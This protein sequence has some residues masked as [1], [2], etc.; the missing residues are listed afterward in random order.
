MS[1]PFVRWLSA[2]LF[3]VRCCLCG[4]VV[5]WSEHLCSRCRQEAPYI[6]PP[7]CAHCGRSEDDCACGGHRRHYARCVTPF[8]REG[9]VTTAVN[10]LKA[11]AWADDVRGFAIEMAEVL[12][13]EYGG[14][15]FDAVT[16]VPLHKKDLR[17]REHN[18][19][20]L[21]ARALA[22]MV[23]VPY[24][25]LLEK[26]TRTRPQKELKAIERTGNLLGVFEVT[27]PAFVAD[28]T[29]L[30]VDDIITTGATLDECA[31]ML[32]IYGAEEV[33]AVTACAAVLQKNENAV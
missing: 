13:R 16:A 15:P 22:D 10:R 5:A 32:K 26:L 31:K 12:R 28:K 24:R 1:R 4:R 19:A 23:G 27:D 21:L 2:W 33:Y 9:V 8:R 14:I 3:P 30:L 7:V 29:I 6:L 20:E 25:P 17:R 11:D 18:D